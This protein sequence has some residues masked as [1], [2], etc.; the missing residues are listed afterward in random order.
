MFLNVW[1][2][3]TLDVGIAVSS[4]RRLD[5]IFLSDQISKGKG[6]QPIHS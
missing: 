3:I 2:A 1:N 6:L 4:Q 5:N